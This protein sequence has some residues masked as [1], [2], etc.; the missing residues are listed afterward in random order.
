MI[1]ICTAGNIPGV[2]RT[3]PCYGQDIPI[4]RHPGV[5]IL[6]IHPENRKNYVVGTEE[7]CVLQCSTAQPNLHFNSFFAH[8]GPCYSI[9]YSPFCSKLLLTCGADWR[10]RIWAEGLENPLMEFGTGM[11]TVSAATWSPKNST[12]FASA[13]FNEVHI[14]KVFVIIYFYL[15]FN[16]KIFLHLRFAYGISGEK[17]IG[18]LQQRD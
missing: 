3:K 1:N 10:I 11:T 13:T 4:K 14:I 8:N 5:L 16:T 6:R 12:V 17:H 18:Q 2:N 7:G 9:E 15:I